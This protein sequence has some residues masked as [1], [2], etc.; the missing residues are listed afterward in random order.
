MEK[1][2]EK[3]ETITIPMENVKE[4]LEILTTTGL[5]LCA[6]GSCCQGMEGPEAEGV[7]IIVREIGYA[8]GEA[9]DLLEDAQD[10]QVAV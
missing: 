4:I 9:K 5:K 2:A 10:H 1:K 3:S 6:V 7:E 8:L